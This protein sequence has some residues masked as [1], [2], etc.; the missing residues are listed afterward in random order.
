MNLSLEIQHLMQQTKVLAPSILPGSG[1]FFPPAKKW[2]KVCLL[3]YSDMCSILYGDE[4]NQQLYVDLFYKTNRSSWQNSDTKRKHTE[5][6]DR[7]R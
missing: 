2:N 7:N 3:K 1:I 4:E 5:S 6:G